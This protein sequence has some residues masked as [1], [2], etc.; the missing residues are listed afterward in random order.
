MN[1]KSL[2]ELINMCMVIN[3]NVQVLMQNKVG[4][5]SWCG[6]TFPGGHL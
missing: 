5:S 4:N 6:L 2:I 1:K 3:K